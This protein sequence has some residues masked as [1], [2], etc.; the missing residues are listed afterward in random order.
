MRVLP[1]VEETK[2]HRAM[3]LVSSALL[4]LTFVVVAAI[5]WV[6]RPGAPV[7]EALGVALPPGSRAIHRERIEAEDE[8]PYAAMYISATW[9][10]S[11]AAEHFSRLSGED[12]PGA[13]RFMLED[14]TTVVIAPADDVPATRLMPIHPVSEG[15]PLGTGSWII[16]T[17]GTPPA[18]TWSAAVPADLGEV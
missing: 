8:A 5:W 15:V 13:R 6:S 1:S 16:V 14:G 10:I 4:S 2:R 3:L 18:A 9:S 17:R 11:E 7:D 12:D